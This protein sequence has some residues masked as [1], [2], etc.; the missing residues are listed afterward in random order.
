M[1]D[2][3]THKCCTV[4]VPAARFTEVQHADILYAFAPTTGEAEALN[5]AAHP[6]SAWGAFLDAQG[7]P[8]SDTGEAQFP[9]REASQPQSIGHAAS[10]GHR[11]H[12]DAHQQQ[13]V[14]A[15]AQEHDEALQRS[16]HASENGHQ[17]ADDAGQ[18]H[19]H[20][21]AHA[22][23]DRATEQPGDEEADGHAVE[24][25][26]EADGLQEQ[27]V[28]AAGAKRSVLGALVS[29]AVIASYATTMTVLD[30]APA[31]VRYVRGRPEPTH[32]SLPVR[33]FRRATT[34]SWAAAGYGIGAL[35]APSVAVS[36]LFGWGHQ[37]C[38]L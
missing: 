14:F 17:A 33:L 22:K 19:Q 36:R 28:L 8:V 37:A 11:S 1:L 16:E 2:E 34:S 15:A 13:P 20:V 32:G 7:Q 26:E 21:L 6:A 12:N 29:R 23:C 24:D 25:N 27:P 5:Q 30:A 35:E 31:A 38:L 3:L 9:A 18:Q 4:D 10:N